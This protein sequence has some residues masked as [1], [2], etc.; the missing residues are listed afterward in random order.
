MCVHS[1]ALIDLAQY[2]GLLWGARDSN[3]GSAM[4]QADALLSELRQPQVSYAAPYL[5]YAA[6]S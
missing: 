6:P 4:H 1:S 5:S 2:M 3:P